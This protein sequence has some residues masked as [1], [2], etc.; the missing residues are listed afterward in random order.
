[1]TR[2]ARA[3]GIA[4]ALVYRWRKRL[5][6]ERIGAPIAK[7]VADGFI[8]LALPVPSALRLAPAGMIEI[9]LLNGRR[10]RVDG[11]VDSALLKRMIDVLER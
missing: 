5:A 11:S 3:H 2:V 10:L 8:P 7:G 9:E 4:S 1:V 6:G